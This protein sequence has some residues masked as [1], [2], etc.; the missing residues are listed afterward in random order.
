LKSFE[1]SPE[2]AWKILGQLGIDDPS[3]DLVV[4]CTNLLNL[5]LIGL[6]KSQEPDFDFSVLSHRADLWK[7][8]FQ[9]LLDRE[10]M[11]AN[12][13]S[14]QTILKEAVNLSRKALESSELK[15]S[16]GLA[17]SWEAQRLISWGVIVPL[18]GIRYRFRHE[19]VQAFIYAWD[20]VSRAAMPQNVL[21]ELP[22]FSIN[23]V[24]VWMGELY[25]RQ[26]PDDLYPRFLRSVFN[27]Q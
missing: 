26:S 5:D 12:L 10:Q 17:P 24:L 14:E 21:E 8:F 6:L 19:E 18:D 7:R 3:E 13:S 16:L 11:S 9:T 4:L 27:V 20:A 1:L 23:S 2:D 25:R 15:L 22:A